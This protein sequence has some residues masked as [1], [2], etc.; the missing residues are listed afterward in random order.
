MLSFPVSVL[1]YLSEMLIAF[2]ILS[3]LAEKRY[4]DLLVLAIGTS[5]FSL[6]AAVNVLSQ[7]TVW[8]NTLS[9]LVIH[10][11]FAALCFRMPVLTAFICALF[12]DLLGI[13][14]EFL[15]ILPITAMIGKDIKAYNSSVALLIAESTVSKA[16]YFLAALFL[17]RLIRQH[18]TKA[19]MKLPTG[20]LFPP[21]VSLAAFVALFEICI[22]NELREESL[23]LMTFVSL[24][25]LL[26]ELVL[27][28]LFVHYWERE[29]EY[30]GAREA[31]LHAETEKAYFDLL[32]HQNHQLMLYAHDANHHIAA[33]RALND[34]EQIDNYI[35]ELYDRLH[36]YTK[37]C[38]SGNRTLDVLINKTVTECE[39][40]EI[41]FDYDV[42]R[43]N[44]G[45]VRDVDLVSLCGNLMDNA[46]AAAKVSQ[47]KQ[48]QLSTACHNSCGIVTISNSCDK[49]PSSEG[50][51]LITQKEDSAKHGFGMQSVK[52][53]LE[54]YHGDYSWEYDSERKEF[55]VTL[56][57]GMEA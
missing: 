35:S 43:Y 30:A 8:V 9:A 7:N 57:I 17:M 40:F 16:F 20:L 19:G 5:I 46:V 55:C 14:F 49:R 23:M 54:N 6:G 11:L 1:I 13:A 36:N 28:V 50:K 24:V 42:R 26:S 4:I 41:R 48:I 39:M 33:I 15:T 51:R 32:E 45:N 25:L 31:L 53:T 34:N 12:I 22:R 10:F 44:L 56:M 52:K 3:Q 27:I 37:S 47:K 29:S 18:G 21:L 2:T 38:H